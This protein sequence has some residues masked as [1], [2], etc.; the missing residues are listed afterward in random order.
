VQFF[1]S[2]EQQGMAGWPP[3]KYAAVCDDTTWLKTMANKALAK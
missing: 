1:V 3:L 2:S